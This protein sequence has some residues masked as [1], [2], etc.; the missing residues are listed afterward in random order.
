[1]KREYENPTHT[2]RLVIP[3]DQLYGGGGGG[4][5]ESGGGMDMNNLLKLLMAAHAAQNS[6]GGLGNQNFGGN[7]GF[8]DFG[9][10]SPDLG[11]EI[12]N[13]F[14]GGEVPALGG[15][16]GGGNKRTAYWE[17]SIKFHFGCFQIIT[18]SHYKNTTNTVQ[19]MEHRL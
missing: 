3:A 5:M 4:G 2:I 14:G 1:M 6:G 17:I 16:A 9:N 7:S 12:G 18:K 19:C 10:F 15:G 8:G 11:G 13:Q